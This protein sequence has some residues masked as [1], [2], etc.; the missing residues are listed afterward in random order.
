MVPKGFNTSSDLYY[1]FLPKQFL[2][3]REMTSHLLNHLTCRARSLRELRSI[4]IVSLRDTSNKIIASGPA[5]ESN[6]SMRLLQ[7]LNVGRTFGS[8]RTGLMRVCSPGW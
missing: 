6:K 1:T 3:G 5:I 7:G 4:N 8:Y 2:C